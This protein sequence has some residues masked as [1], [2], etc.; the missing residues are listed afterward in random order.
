MLYPS[1]AEII[2]SNRDA[3]NNLINEILKHTNNENY[4]IQIDEEYESEH[5]N[6]T[7]IIYNFGTSIDF[8][9]GLEILADKDTTECVIVGQAIPEMDLYNLAYYDG[10][11]WSYGEGDNVEE[12]V[13]KLF[14]ID[15]SEL[16]LSIDDD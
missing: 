11:D 7:K 13:K 12:D 9:G 1:R 4:S 15:D 3:A 6:Q 5:E 2:C 10:I 16:E 14:N 8:H